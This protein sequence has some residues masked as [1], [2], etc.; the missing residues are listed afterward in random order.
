MSK[1]ILVG[2]GFSQYNVLCQA[3]DEICKGFINAGYE[4]D[5]IDFHEANAYRYF[6]KCLENNDNYL[7]YFSMQALYWDE[8]KT[9]LPQL[10]DIQRIGW[11]VDD[12]I[13]H[14]ERL[15]GTNGHN[16]TALIVRDSHADIIRRD[17]P[18]IDNVETLYHGGFTCS[19]IIPYNKRKIDVFFP[20]TYTSLSEAEQRVNKIDGI[21]GQIASTMKQQIIGKNLSHFWRDELKAYFNSL[22]V[23]V[24]EKEFHSL[25]YLMSPLDFYQRT[26]MRTHIIE[27][28]LKNNIDVSVVG[29]GWDKYDGI[30]KDHLHILSHTGIDISETVELMG[31]SKIILNNTN[32][33]DGLHERILSAMLAQSVCVTNNYTLLNNLFKNNKELVTFSLDNLAS[34]PNTI[35]NLLQN[36]QESEAIAR[37]GYLSAKKSH[38]WIHR[39]EQIVNYLQTKKPFTY[40]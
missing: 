10:Q 12:P 40:F 6:Q 23:E 7:F 32:I 4:I 3:C 27:T 34:L 39:G 1:K 5:V 26:F 36:A 8:E 35:T 24:S 9:V 29:S 14:D 13:Y 25:E 20:G 28:L 30:G 33:T 17:Y 15:A 31:N 37:N 38:T 11:I 22:H 16:A 19:N 2:R 18:H 21:Y